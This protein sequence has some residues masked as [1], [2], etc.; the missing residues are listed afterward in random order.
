MIVSE[1]TT[2]RPA[3][4]KSITE[5]QR[6]VETAKPSGE[7]KATVVSHTIS[8]VEGDQ[9]GHP[10]ATVNN[11]AKATRRPLDVYLKKY[12]LCVLFAS[13]GGFLFGFDTG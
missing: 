7:A 13:L 5:E 2:S 9:P 6:C 3:S 4:Q 8:T 12:T 11:Q 10:I 1:A